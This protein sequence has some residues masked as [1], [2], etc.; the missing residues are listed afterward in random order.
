MIDPNMMM[1]EECKFVAALGPLI[2]TGAGTAWVS[3]KLYNK[4]TVLISA[5]N[6]TTVTPATV[7]LSQAQNVSGLNAKAL[8][9]TNVRANLDTSV[10][11]TLVDTPVVSNTFSLGAVNLK[12]MIYEIT[13]DETMLDINGFFRCLHVNIGAATAQTVSVLYVLWPAKVGRGTP[14]SAVV[15]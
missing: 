3:L 12:Q 6:G 10:N 7:S 9:F 14:P 15:D 13:I 5:L 1:S 2:P 8:P 11:D 4:V